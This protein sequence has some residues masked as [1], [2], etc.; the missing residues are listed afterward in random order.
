MVFYYLQV[1]ITTNIYLT[2]SLLARCP[3][4][5]KD[6]SRHFLMDK[7]G[8]G[9]PIIFSESL[10]ISGRKPRYRLLDDTELELTIWAANMI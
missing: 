1:S 4:N 2:Y 3:V 6:I 10:K 5:H 8:E 9:V 7:R